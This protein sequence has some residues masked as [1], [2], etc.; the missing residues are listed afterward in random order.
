MT[1]LFSVRGNTVYSQFTFVFHAFLPNPYRLSVSQVS[2]NYAELAGKGLSGLAERRGASI[3]VLFALCKMSSSST[4]CNNFLVGNS[5]S[6]APNLQCEL[7][8]SFI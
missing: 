3:A 8:L 1:V 7:H 4:R 2:L 5:S 6:M